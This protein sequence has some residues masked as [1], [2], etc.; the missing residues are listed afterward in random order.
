ML[1]E[2]SFVC[3]YFDIQCSSTVSRNVISS[4]TSATKGLFL[5]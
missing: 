2:R 4:W 3:I 5:K 1:D